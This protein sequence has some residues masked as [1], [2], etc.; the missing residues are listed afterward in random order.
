VFSIGFDAVIKIAPEPPNAPFISEGYI[1][2]DL[3]FILEE[4]E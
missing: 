3:C 4:S 1:N 2:G